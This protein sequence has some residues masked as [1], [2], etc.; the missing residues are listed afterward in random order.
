M[1][2][3][4]KWLGFSEVKTNETLKNTNLTK[5]LVEIVKLAKGFDPT[6]KNETINAKTKVRTFLKFI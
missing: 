5:Q 1:A 3:E 4:I 6:E 2:T